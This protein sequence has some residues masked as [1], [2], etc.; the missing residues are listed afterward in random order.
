M[1]ADSAR[2]S[3]RTM[4]V[5]AVAAAHGFAMWLIWRVVLPLPSEPEAFTSLLFW[6]PA[7]Q[8]APPPL[9]AHPRV[10]V[11][12]APRPASLSAAPTPDSGTAITLPAA[13]GAQVD[14]R[15]ALPGAAA[16]EIDQ[17]KR[18]SEQVRAVTR[19]YAVEDDPRDSHP[20]PTSSFRWYEAGTHRIDTRSWIPVLHLNDRCV[21]VIFIMPACAIG[22]IESHGDL[23]EG[24]ALVHDEKLATPRPNDAP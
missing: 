9:A 1:A 7:T 21:L 8:P 11:T 13:P 22:H 10:A 14:W 2:V 18:L 6:L 4:T 12:P 17:Q 20:G 16:T 24:A 3:S 23:F 5:L 15:A 19:R